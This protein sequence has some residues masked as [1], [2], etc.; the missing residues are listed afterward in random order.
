MSLTTRFGPLPTQSFQHD[1]HMRRD[2]TRP[3]IFHLNIVEE[4]P[5]IRAQ[6]SL[7]D[8]TANAAPKTTGVGHNAAIL[9]IARRAHPWL[10]T[11]HPETTQVLP[12][13]FTAPK[14]RRA[15]RYANGSRRFSLMKKSKSRVHH[16]LVSHPEHR[17]AISDDFSYDYPR[18][19]HLR[20]TNHGGCT[21]L[22]LPTQ[23]PRWSQPMHPS[24]CTNLGA[25]RGPPA[26]VR[27]HSD[28]VHPPPTSRRGTHSSGS[29]N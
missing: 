3:P 8:E 20:L 7:I 15:I 29:A 9:S 16:Y 10:P 19:F 28:V 1:L 22:Q 6:V 13:C 24:S 18:S 11:I 23:P 5:N 27:I 14:G 25:I 2:H 4:R 12:L 17:R 26:T 21:P